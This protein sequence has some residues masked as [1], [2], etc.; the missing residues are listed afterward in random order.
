VSAKKTSSSSTSALKSKDSQ[1]PKEAQYDDDHETLDAD[2]EEDS[3]VEWDSG[4]F[5]KRVDREAHDL[6]GDDD[7]NEDVID[8]SADDSADAEA[9]RLSNAIHE[10]LLHRRSADGDRAMSEKERQERLANYRRMRQEMDPKMREEILAMHNSNPGRYMRW[11]GA[12]IL[13]F[14]VCSLALIASRRRRNRFKGE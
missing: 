9:K 10:E 11:A 4:A 14:G 2:A 3:D 13:I 5:E 7:D 6:L 8:D 12:G 1:E